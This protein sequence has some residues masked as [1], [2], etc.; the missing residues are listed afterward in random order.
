MRRACLILILVA[1]FLGAGSEAVLAGHAL[2]DPVATTNP[3]NFWVSGNMDCDGTSVW[4]GVATFNANAIFTL[5][6]S[7]GDDL[8]V[9]DDVSCDSLY[10]GSNLT[11]AD[12][13]TVLGPLKGARNLIIY[14]DSGSNRTND[15][16]LYTGKITGST[17]RGL[18]LIRAGSFIGATGGCNIDSYTPGA[19][20]EVAIYLDG[21]E[22]CTAL[23][24]VDAT[25]WKN[26]HAT[27]ARGAHTFAAD[28][29]IGI[30]F[31]ITGTVQ[32]D[33]PICGVEIQNDD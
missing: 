11:V 5:D 2:N 21:V 6:V 9:T 30:Y 7:V 16:W 18:G 33:Y 27:W 17:A 20:V 15:Q 31:D 13:L 23:W 10:V 4:D 24:T 25:G 12:T 29:F 19:T 14:D 1:L 32:W 3:G 28:Q 8:I 26:W 22:Q